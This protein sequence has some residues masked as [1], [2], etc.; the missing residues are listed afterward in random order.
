LRLLGF[1]LALAACGREPAKQSPPAEPPPPAADEAHGASLTADRR[2]EA[3]ALISRF[4][5]A[6]CHEGLASAPVDPSKH[7][8]S[9]HRGLNEGQYLDV[10]ADDLARWRARSYSLRVVPNLAAV[11]ARVRRAWLADFLLR[12]VDLRPHL[13]PTMPRLALEPAQ[14]A[15]LA[16]YLVP[17]ETLDA[18]PSG[19]RTKGQVLFVSR[20]C[21]TCHAMTGTPPPTSAF[22]AEG[23]EPRNAVDAFAL[24][25]DLARVRAR[26]Q[27]GRLV[28]WLLDPAVVDPT[29]HMPRVG[30]TEAEARDLSAFLLET[31]PPPPSPPPSPEARLPVLARAVPFAEVAEKVFHKVCWHCHAAPFYALGDGGP[32]NTGGFGFAARGLDLSTHEGVLSGSI[33]GDGRRRGLFGPLADG[34]PRLVAHLMARRLEERGGVV[35]GVR[36]M[37]L[38]LPALAL[39]DI[40]VVES[41]IAQDRPE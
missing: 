14:A 6:R 31:E 4:E 20:G 32:G 39:E 22:Q 15:L 37:P 3:E 8:V 17:R 10:P 18:P 19:D 27:P 7:C 24:A 1:L 11:G 13:V 12:P 41:W 33:G 29:T 35:P 23:V 16:E 5:C 21:A 2:R 36:G 26:V 9:C 30:L 28:P 25:P 40:Q 34:T 38:G